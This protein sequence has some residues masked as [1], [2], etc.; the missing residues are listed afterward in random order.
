MCLF[1]SFKTLNA[2]KT[3]YHKYLIAV[4]PCFQLIPNQSKQIVS[5][6]VVKNFSFPVCIIFCSR[7]AHYVDLVIKLVKSIFERY[8]LP[9]LC[10]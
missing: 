10:R 9:L 3:N 1:L 6:L 4:R 5:Y 7:D 8:I 2:T